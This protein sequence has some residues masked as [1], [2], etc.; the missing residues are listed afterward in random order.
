MFLLEK[1]LNKI[2]KISDNLFLTN[3]E[4]ANNKKKV[5]KRGVT[6]IINVC[7]EKDQEIDGIKYR[8]FPVRDSEQQN[9]QQ[10]FSAI[11][12]VIDDEI[13]RGGKV[14]IHCE[15]GI[16]RSS[17]VVLAWQMHR[18]AADN[19]DVS[20]DEHLKALQ[21]CRPMAEPNSGFEKQLRQYAETLNAG[22]KTSKQ[23][24]EKTT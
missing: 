6:L 3:L 20:F 2:S 19:K 14:L 18:N 5:L 1:Q 21:E 16:S 23:I 24:L 12:A 13:N 8:A 11:N 7:H 10:H 22:I 9:I 15:Q 17:T 4:G